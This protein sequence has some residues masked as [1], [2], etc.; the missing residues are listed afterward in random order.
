MHERL[1]RSLFIVAI[2]LLFLTLPLSFISEKSCRIAFYFCSYLSIVGIFIN[3]RK[4]KSAITST[5]IV[6]PFFALSVM[7]AV[8]SVIA[9]HYAVADVDNGLLFT[10]AKRWFLATLISMFILWGIREEFISQPLLCKLAWISFAAAFIFSSAGGIWQ[11]INGIERITLGINRATMTAYAYSAMALTM[12]I[13]LN[14]INRVS[15]RHISILFAYLLSVY[16]IFLTETRSAMFIHIT[17]GLLLIIKTLCQSKSLKLVPISAIIISFCVVGILGKNIIA[18]RFDTT[19]QEILKFNEGDDHTSLGS[20]FTMWKSG[21][22][23]IAENPLGETQITRNTIIKEW[24]VASHN[25][26]SFAL[27]YID[28]H[29]HNEFIQYASLFGIAGVIVLL[30]FFGKLLFDNGLRGFLGNPI[31]VVTL[32]ALL[33]GMTD[34]LFISVE[35]VVVFST[36]ILLVR[37]SRYS[38]ADQSPS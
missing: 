15:L 24:L 3:Y 5:K 31:S 16:I 30:F 2:T 29:L 22:V 14:R 12:M 37:A 35:Y 11:H 6:L 13:M 38:P 1:T 18:S 33:Y 21:M 34:V 10:P 20:R 27:D 8:W 26:N 28:V 7:Y 19:K 17:L 9:A 36:L 4:T 23:A 25:P 32:S